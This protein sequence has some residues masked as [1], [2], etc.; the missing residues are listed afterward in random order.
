LVLEAQEGTRGRD[1]FL[2]RVSARSL[3]SL[4]RGIPVLD[5]ER[6]ILARRPDDWL[7][8]LMDRIHLTAG[9]AGGNPAAEP[10]A[11]NLKKSGYQLR[12][13]LTVRKIAEIKCRALD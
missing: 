6:E 13:W 5:L 8:N 2:S 11:E 3:L 9:Q 12:G 1:H 4:E 10:T 7:G